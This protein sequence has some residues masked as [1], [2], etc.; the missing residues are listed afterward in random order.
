RLLLVPLTLKQFHSMRAL[1]TLQPQLKEIQNKYKEDKQRQQQEL[2]KF[3]KENNV[4]PLASCLPLVAQLPVFISL[5]YMLRKDLRDNI[6]PSVQA[7]YRAAKHLGKSATVACTKGPHGAHAAG[8]AHAGF[9]FIKDLTNNATGATLVVLI[10]LYVGTQLAS[11]LM[12][13]TPT[14]D[15]TQRKLMMFMPLIFVLFIV[16]FPAGVIVYWVTTNSWTILQ[17]FIVRRRLG[18]ATPPAAAMA[19]SGG[20][21]APAASGRSAPASSDDAPTNGASSSGGLGGLLRGR[22]KQEEVAVAT[23]RAGPPPRP[24]RK[25]K[26]RSGR[27]R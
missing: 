14:M 18:P 23:Q 19:T 1:Q 3:Y 16:N 15:P 8:A 12:M 9:L 7:S 27:R 13:S 22:G 5:F 25:K 11:T 24:P 4:N 10:L 20:G 6:C 17:Q 26:K 2:M 21:S